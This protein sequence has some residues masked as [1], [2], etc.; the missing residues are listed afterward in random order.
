MSLTNIND[1]ALETILSDKLE[2]IEVAPCSAALFTQI[3]NKVDQQNTLIHAHIDNHE[4]VGNVNQYYIYIYDMDVPPSQPLYSIPENSTYLGLRFDDASSLSQDWWDFIF[5]FRELELFVFDCKLSVLAALLRRPDEIKAFLPNL[6]VLAITIKW[7][8]ETETNEL[9]NNLQRTIN[10]IFA[11][12]PMIENVIFQL[13]GFGTMDL[14]SKCENMGLEQVNGRSQIT[15]N[16]FNDNKQEVEEISVVGIDQHREVRAINDDDEK[17]WGLSYQIQEDQ[18]TKIRYQVSEAIEEHPE[19][20]DDEDGQSKAKDEIRIETYPENDQT[21]SFIR[22]IIGKTV[23]TCRKIG[24]R[25][26]WS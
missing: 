4:F 3:I 10:E 11:E 25:L 24:E 20:N 14:G 22:D 26:F 7:E 21:Y 8:R 1:D 12:L 2:F 13:V 9:Q 16:C 23:D 18:K 17:E 6:S 19:T 5:R 15:F